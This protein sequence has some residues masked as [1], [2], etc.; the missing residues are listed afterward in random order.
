M[1]GTRGMNTLRGAQ[2]R[3][4]TMRDEHFD[5]NHKINEDKIDIDWHSHREALEDTKIDVFVQANDNAVA[6]TGTLD[7]TSIIGGTQ[8]SPDVATEGIVDGAKVELRLTGTEDTPVADVDG[9]PIYGK[10]RYDDDSASPTPVPKFYV[11]FYSIVDGS[12]TPFTFAGDAG[13]VDIVYI[14]RTNM[15]VI[16]VD[17]I[18]NGGAGFVEGATDAKAYFNLVQLMKD[19]Y[20]D[21][22]VLDN[23]GNANLAMSI[24]DQINKEITD[25][26]NADTKIRTDLASTD[27][28]F[29]G[30]LVGLVTDANHAGNTVQAAIT[31]IA[32]RV[33][34]IE[35][36][37]GS[38]IADL[39]SRDAASANGYFAER[40]EGNG[41]EFATVEERLVDIET[42]VDAQAK[43]LE[44][45]MVKQ[46][47]EDVREVYEATGGE[48]GYTLVDGIARPNTLYLSINGALQV[49]G[50]HYVEVKDGD[51]N[52]T[53]VDFTPDTL[54]VE[55]DVPDN[56]MV[57]Y[58]K[59]FA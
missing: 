38:E 6:G 51:G 10:M 43:Q 58:K 57:W 24:Q 25:R 21:T 50:L 41:G 55:N 53:G 26:T 12:E 59:V 52:I 14:Q 49:P 7:I 54:K 34:A 45:R 4:K 22:G 36:Q 30:A 1:A 11:D 19:I 40:T 20:G 16:P 33:V 47:T 8:V 46:E 29:G 44:D 15:S 3:Q 32:A 31:D 42:V 28:D 17:A 18:V 39:R 56:L 48:T 27:A 23:D 5:V 2:L 13:N 9:D 37:L 35:D